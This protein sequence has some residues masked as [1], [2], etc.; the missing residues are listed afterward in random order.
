MFADDELLQDADAEVASALTPAD[1]E[2]CFDVRAGLGNM[3]V[4]FERLAAIEA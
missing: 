4:V 1:L 2:A 3:D